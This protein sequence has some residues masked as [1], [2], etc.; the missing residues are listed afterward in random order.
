M[1]ST[2]YAKA[3]EFYSC[4]IAITLDNAVYYCNRGA[5]L[6]KIKRFHEAVGDCCKAI[7]LNSNYTKAYYRLGLAYSEQGKYFDAIWDGFLK[8]LQLDPRNKAALTQLELAEGKLSDQ[9]SWLDDQL[10][11]LRKSGMITR[12]RKVEIKEGTALVYKGK[13]EDGDSDKFELVEE[14]DVDASNIEETMS[15]SEFINLFSRANIAP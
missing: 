11:K 8:V 13:A 7:S 1:E 4:A 3:A 12:C 15:I 2:C 14:D 9:L 6:I 5:A 10:E